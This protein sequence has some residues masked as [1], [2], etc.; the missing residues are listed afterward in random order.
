[1]N[2]KTIKKR[3]RNLKPVSH[4]CNPSYSGGRD[5]EDGSSKPI[6]ADSL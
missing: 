5:K 4:T 3:S 1:M 2:N 6:W